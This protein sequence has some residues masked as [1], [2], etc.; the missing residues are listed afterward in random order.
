MSRKDH[1]LTTAFNPLKGYMQDLNPNFVFSF[2]LF[3]V[4]GSISGNEVSYNFCKQVAFV[5]EVRLC[6]DHLVESK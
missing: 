2:A 1:D 4:S 6:I 3:W 5:N